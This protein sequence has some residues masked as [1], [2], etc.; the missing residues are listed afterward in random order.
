MSVGTEMSASVDSAPPIDAPVPDKATSPAATKSRVEKY[1][2]TRRDPLDDVEDELNAPEAGDDIPDDEVKAKGKKPPVKPAAPKATAKPRPSPKPREGAIKAPPE[3]RYADKPTEAP[4]EK[5]APKE[6]VE[7]P[8]DPKLVGL[9]DEWLGMTPAEVKSLGTPEVMRRLQK[10]YTRYQAAQG[11]QKQPAQQAPAQQPAETPPA[12]ERPRDASG[13]FAPFKP[14]NPDD[15]SPEFLKY[16]AHDEARTQEL[17]KVLEPILEMRKE[18]ETRRQ[19]EAQAHNQKVWDEF[20]EAVSELDAELFGQGSLAD[21]KVPAQY[22]AR[23]VL[24]AAVTE[25]A[26]FH[27]KMNEQMNLPVPSFKAIVQQAYQQLHADRQRDI[28]ARRLSEATGAR[29]QFTTFSGSRQQ[30][31][32]HTDPH[33]A[34]VR[35]VKEYM[36]R[37]RAGM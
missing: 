7:H 12:Q 37:R 27:R 24:A 19:Q 3:P 9:A 29:R 18:M 28:E 26:N 30:T 35:G 17:N 1:L 25:F 23:R 34:A 10:A 13:R 6:A 15:L 2:D 5:P 11:Q 33:Q 22:Q 21:V 16:L 32:E 31:T 4:A 36:E 8:V 14:E 20:D